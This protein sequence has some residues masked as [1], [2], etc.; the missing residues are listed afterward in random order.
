MLDR[1]LEIKSRLSRGGRLIAQAICWMFLIEV[2]KA[3]YYTYLKYTFEYWTNETFS[4]VAGLMLAH[5]PEIRSGRWQRQRHFLPSAHEAVFVWN[6][7]LAHPL[8]GK[9]LNVVSFYFNRA[10]FKTVP[11][12]STMFDAVS[13]CKRFLFCQRMLERSSI[14]WAAYHM[15][16]QPLWSFLILFV[17]PFYSLQ[18]WLL[19]RG[20]FINQYQSYVWRILFTIDGWWPMCQTY[21][22]IVY[23]WSS[24]SKER[25]NTDCSNSVRWTEK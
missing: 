15:H 11:H 21:N 2:A 19:G 9:G 23:R 8:Y 24:S 3:T 12:D 4:H 10:G 18:V 25:S 13:E 17:D 16:R 22:C 7:I 20:Y 14:F 5:R 6:T 1:L